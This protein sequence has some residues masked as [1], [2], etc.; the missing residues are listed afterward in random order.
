MVFLALAI[1]SR[2]VS[3]RIWGRDDKVKRL[4]LSELNPYY[5]NFKWEVDKYFVGEGKDK[6][7]SI[8]TTVSKLLEGELTRS[9]L[10]LTL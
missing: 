4:K 6:L 8:L 9:P 1:K 3:R 10:S 7:A 2:A 5:W